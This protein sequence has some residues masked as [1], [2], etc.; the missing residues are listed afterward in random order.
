MYRYELH[1]HTRQG[2][3][4][5]QWDIEDMI[6]AYA[7]RG[8]TGAVVTDH[9]LGGNTCIDRSLP[10]EEIVAAYS[11]AYRRGQAL[12]KE[13]DFDLLFGIEEGYGGG[14]EFLVYGVEPEFLLERPFLRSAETAVWSR[15]VHGV[16]GV[17][18]Y[19]HPFRNRPYVTDPRAMPDMSLADG[20]EIF[21]AWNLPEDNEEADRIFGNMD[22]IHIV[23]SD[24]HRGDGDRF[25]GVDF[26][27]RVRTSAEL[28]AALKSR[29]H[30]LVLRLP[31][32]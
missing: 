3:A 11:T 20:V 29:E 8:Y 28:A 4:C 12:A 2:S 27:H 1:M 24:N 7:A 15:E 13:L 26:S 6:R 5:G 25:C 21:N 23:G 10:W 31:A 16:G 32:E 19:A 17:L 18:I 30:T 9:F 22:C 14:K